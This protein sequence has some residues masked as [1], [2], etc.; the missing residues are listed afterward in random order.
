M[1]SRIAG[2]RVASAFFALVCVLHVLR[3]LFATE[4]V[5]AGRHLPMWLSAPAALITGAL[6]YWFCRL[7]STEHQGG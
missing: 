1:N 5:I 3:L 2:L 7:S 4:I 6:S